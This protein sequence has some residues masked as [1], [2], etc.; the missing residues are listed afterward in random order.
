LHKIYKKNV[1]RP[2]AD[3]HLLYTGFFFKNQEKRKPS[4]EIHKYPINIYF[5]VGEGQID[6]MIMS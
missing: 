3:S 4:G 6:H 2:K 1:A 5:K